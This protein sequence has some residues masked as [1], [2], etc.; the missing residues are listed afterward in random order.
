MF[1][2]KLKILKFYQIL[3]N[4]HVR[5]IFTDRPI[6]AQI[7]KIINSQLTTKYSVFLKNIR[8]TIDSAQSSVFINTK[9]Y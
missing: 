5:E 4:N 8:S 6:D 9:I 2:E 3:S 1:S 7:I